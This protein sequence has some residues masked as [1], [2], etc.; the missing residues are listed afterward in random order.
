[1]WLHHARVAFVYA[2]LLLIATTAQ[3][4]SPDTNAGSAIGLNNAIVKALKHNPELIALGHQLDAQDARILQ[5]GLAP[6]PELDVYFEDAL[7]TGDFSG[8][9]SSQTTLSLAYVLERGKREKRVDAARA[10]LDALKIDEEI[11]RLNVA[12][13]TARRFLASLAFQARLVRTDEA[14]ELARDTVQ[15][16][17]KRVRAS[18]APKAEMARAEAQLA[19]VELEREDIDHELLSAN[20]RLAAQ[21]GSSD[22]NFTRV[23]GDIYELPDT[24]SFASLKQQLEQSPDLTRFLSEQRLREAELRLAQARSRPNWRVTAGVRRHERENDQSFV[25]G[26]TIPLSWNNR[27]QGRIAETR[28]ALA[29]TGADETAARIRI[30]TELFVLYQEALHSLHRANTVRE[31]IIPRA[32]AALEETRRAYNLGRYGYFEWQV[33]Q[34]E[35][36]QART[37][38]VDASADAHRNVVEIERLTGL[39]FALSKQKP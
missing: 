9:G 31:E 30:E 21:W 23:R 15:A 12:A 8:L 18:R 3:A 7:G 1:M 37:D 4:Q 11:A 22:P 28:A 16:V 39:P 34:A 20:R 38:F 35:L 32:E 17:N 19:R 14:V 24:V 6:N 33:A 27:N 36:L 29:R 5:A 10:G 25:A 13:E 2:A 26:I